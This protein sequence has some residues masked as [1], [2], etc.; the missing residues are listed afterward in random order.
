M[1]SIIFDC[2]PWDDET[3]MKE[4]EAGVRAI[5]LDG[6]TWQ[7]SKFVEVAYGVKKL[8]IGCKVVDDIVSV[9]EIEEKIMELTDFVQSVDIAA[10]V[11]L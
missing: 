4:M 11:K 1:S 9:D 5:T 6:L 2:K 3:D 10:F 8:Q 7:T